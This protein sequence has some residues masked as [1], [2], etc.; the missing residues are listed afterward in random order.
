MIIG[1]LHVLFCLDIQEL[2]R[3]ALPAPSKRCG[4]KT[5]RRCSGGVITGAI[6]TGSARVGAGT[7]LFC[8]L[9]GGSA[10]RSH[11]VCLLRPRRV[12]G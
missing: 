5:Y 9:I 1:R 2:G 10:R 12:R 11:L 8:F 4:H 3:R 6:L 7:A